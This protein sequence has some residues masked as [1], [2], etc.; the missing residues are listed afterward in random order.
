VIPGYR[1]LRNDRVLTGRSP[2]AVTV[3]L[4]QQRPDIGC[5]L[6][7]RQLAHCLWAAAGPASRGITIVWIPDQ[8]LRRL[9]QFRLLAADNLEDSRVK[10]P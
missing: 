9:R 4:A 6:C 3:I 7:V 1:D 8:V 5:Q 10:A 2:Y